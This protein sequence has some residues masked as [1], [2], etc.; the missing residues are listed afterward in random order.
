MQNADALFCDYKNLQEKYKN[1]PIRQQ[2][3]NMHAHF[4]PEERI[5][6]YE[7]QR[8][9][10]AVKATEM[11]TVSSTPEF[12]A[13]LEQAAPVPPNRVN[14][15]DIKLIEFEIE[16][17]LFL[18]E[19]EVRNKILNQIP[20]LYQQQKI[21]GDARN[22]PINTLLKEIFYYVAKAG[23]KALD[24]C[25]LKRF[26]TARK[27][28]LKG[29]WERPNGLVRQASIISEQKRQQAKNAENKFAKEF[30]QKWIQG[31]A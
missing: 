8:A 10:D 29:A 27:L 9:L 18:V 25:Q 15:S 21:L 1:L 23:S 7:H 30:T 3:Q 5:K 16:G 24:A 14:R 31:V 17:E 2:I 13:K 6:I 4:S 12:K 20:N 28:C 11:V 19:E 26:H 22:K